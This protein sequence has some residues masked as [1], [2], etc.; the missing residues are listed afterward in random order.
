MLSRLSLA[1]IVGLEAL[2]AVP[3]SGEAASC[4][5]PLKVGRF[6]RSE[7]QSAKVKRC[8]DDLTTSCGEL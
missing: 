1:L 6:R 2:A 3:V 8:E 5:P 4:A 7:A